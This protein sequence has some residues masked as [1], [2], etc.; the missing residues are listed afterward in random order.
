MLLHVV[1]RDDNLEDRNDVAVVRPL[2]YDISRLGGRFERERES[3]ANRK[4]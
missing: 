2:S 4:C 3:Q 1:I